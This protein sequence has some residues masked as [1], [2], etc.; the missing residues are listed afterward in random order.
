MHKINI[1]EKIIQNCISRRGKRYIF[2]KINLK[3]TALLVIDMQNCF[4]VPILSIVEFSYTFTKTGSLN[5]FL[6]P[7]KVF[8]KSLIDV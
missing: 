5:P 8:I 2:D 1:P 3:S 4:I 6:F 7:T